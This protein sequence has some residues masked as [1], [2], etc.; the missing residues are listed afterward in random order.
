MPCPFASVR[1]FAFLLRVNLKSEQ[2]PS[3]QFGEHLLR[4]RISGIGR[5]DEELPARRDVRGATFAFEEHHAQV[6]QGGDVTRLG[7][8]A[9][10]CSSAPRVFPHS[11]S[12]GIGCGDISLR[13]PAGGEVCP[14]PL[15]Q[16]T[17]ANAH[18]FSAKLSTQVPSGRSG[19]MTI[20]QNR[21]SSAVAVP[22]IA[23]T[24]P[25]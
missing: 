4:H 3:K 13:Y 17:K 21:S 18:F 23:P 2:A 1:H 19:S 8:P 20:M 16:K 14:K 6:V 7:G 25:V 9:I 12:Q 15:M 10:P 24:V 22:I 11:F 5:C